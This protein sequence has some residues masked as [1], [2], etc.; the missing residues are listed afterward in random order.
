MSKGWSVQYRLPSVDEI[1]EDTSLIG[2]V[3]A[4]MNSPQ[5]ELFLEV[6]EATSGVLESADV[7]AKERQIIWDDGEPLSISASAQRIGVEYPEYPLDMIE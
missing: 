7:D 4:Y 3:L 6:G 1:E 2:D 5:G